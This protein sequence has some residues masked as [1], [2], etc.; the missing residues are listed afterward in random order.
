VT[1]LDVSLTDYGL[2]VECLWFSYRMARLPA[3][4]AFALPRLFTAFFLSIAI[5]AVAGGTVHGFF[6]NESSLG[7]RILWPFTLVVVG[8]TALFGVQI[9]AALQF[10]RSSAGY[11]NRGAAMISLAYC[12]V[13]LFVRR[14]FRIAILDYVPALVFLGVAFLL[15]Y[16]RR[17][18]PIL[19]I[20]SIGV[21]TMLFAAAAQQAKIG[22]HPVYFDHNA[23]Y[24]VL[25]G[26]ALFMV[27]LAAR[28]SSRLAESGK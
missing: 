21:C 28:E 24:H 26:I 20:G 13:V 27:F 17:K 9:G 2:A 10:P 19:L 8:L 15:A 5:A 18:T 4:T 3:E 1:Q 25:Q 22:I 7:N 6:L 11:V 23:L 14:D 16:R 12:A